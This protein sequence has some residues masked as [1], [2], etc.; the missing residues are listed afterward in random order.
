[1]K[2]KNVIWATVL[3]TA[4]LSACTKTLVLSDGEKTKKIH[5]W[6]DITA[7]KDSNNNTIL[8]FRS[9]EGTKYTINTSMYTYKIK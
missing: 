4:L 8:S 7:T 1:M 2:I 3:G 5:V 6:R 9:F